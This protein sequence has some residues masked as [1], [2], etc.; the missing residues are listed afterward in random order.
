MP[1]TAT[2]ALDIR[3]FEQGLKTA[4]VSLQTFE[5]AG[6]TL[7]RD[8]ARMMEGFSGEKVALEAS[9]MAEAVG[10]VGGAA[11][12]TES[13]QRRVNATVTEAIAKYQALGQEAPKELLKLQKETSGAV[14]KTSLLSSGVKALVAAFSVQK[15]AQ[16][17][18]A[19]L[20]FAGTLTDLA[21]KTGI[22]VEALQ[23]LGYVTS[24][25]GVSLDQ[26]AD[27]AVKMGRALVTG[28]KSAVAAVQALGLSVDTL[29]AAGPEQAFLQIGEAIARV[30]NPMEQA[31]LATAVFGRAGAEY[32]PAFTANMS[33]V[34]AQAQESGAILSAD[35]VAGGDAAGD[36]LT[37]LQAAGM[38]VLGQFLLP[39]MPAVELIA[40]F[41][42]TQIPRALGAA[43]DAFT[44]LL[45]KGLEVQVWLY[46]MA[47][48]IAQTV[49]DV[50][51]LGR[52]FGQT[53]EDIDALRGMAQHARDSL[54]SFNAQGVQPVKAAVQQAIP[55]TTR[56]AEA[57][58]RT[59][60]SA[61]QA[62]A[63]ITDFIGPLQNPVWLSLPANMTSFATA[64]ENA[65]IAMSHLWQE[66]LRANGEVVTFSSALPR[67]QSTMGQLWEPYKQGLTDAKVSS[68]GF[69]QE[70]FGGAQQFGAGISSIFQAAFTGGGGALG[71]VQSFATQALS[72]L[73]GMIPG[74]GQFVSAFA[75]PIV[76]MFTRL[77]SKADD[78]FRRLFG[79]PS[80]GE[81]NDRNMV[82]EW[83]DQVLESFGR[84]ED[85]TERWER[86]LNAANRALSANGYTAEQIRVII[87]R[88]WQ[89][90]REGGEETWRVIDE[91][92]RMMA[93]GA[94]TV[95]ATIDRIGAAI[96]DLHDVVDIR[97]NFEAGDMPRY[98]E[99]GQAYNRGT[100]GVHGSYFRNF[101]RGTPAMLHGDEAVVR[102]DQAVPFAT[103]VLAAA[104]S[105]VPR[106]R[107]ARA[108]S[109]TD[110]QLLA[111]LR[112]LPMDIK[113]AVREAMAM[114]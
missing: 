5:R 67:L 47:V 85:G 72:G 92:N 14:E 114:A 27:G 37:R 46:D 97:V 100:L 31:A 98:D 16:A 99:N 23:R 51:V 74:V 32:L 19:V 9:R 94:T 90:S 81:L 102:K 10:R 36:A 8:L 55:M 107:V 21:A 101:G 44:G 103:S 17:A 24:Q 60:K 12:L 53:T 87:E 49:R 79:G 109:G 65:A 63:Q 35:L 91:L 59:G 105:P 11:K 15:I 52:V 70:V 68:G 20:D 104:T 96:D 3:N 106:T 29:M 75:G 111:A 84:A 30:P 66:V 57:L 38:S 88:L 93:Q 40:S 73:L 82:A 76:A 71:A 108:V 110:P 25:S 4:E 43:R 89:S 62:G 1:L 39:M 80:Q 26:V 77:I 6:K 113:L 2:L 95:S 61:K 83:E 18:N 33:A 41:M 69:F 13:E 58:E 7:N 34:A 86:V 64:T 112:V 22:G 50:P 54:N 45:R 78:F 42:A 48:S 28:D 56:F